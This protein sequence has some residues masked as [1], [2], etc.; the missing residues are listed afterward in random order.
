MAMVNT[1][2]YSGVVLGIGLGAELGDFIDLDARHHLV[3]NH[4]AF[5]DTLGQRLGHGRHRHAD[6]RGA[7]GGQ[8]LVGQAGRGA[9][10]HALEVFHRLHLLLGGEQVAGAMDVDGED[11][12]VLELVLGIGLGEFPGGAAGGL[13]I[14]HGEGQFEDFR[15]REAVGRVAEHGP[16]HVGDA[17]LGLVEELGRR[18]AELHGRIDLA[19]DAV[20]GFLAELGAPGL[21]YADLDEGRR[22]KKVVHLQCHFLRLGRERGSPAIDAAI[23]VFATAFSSTSPL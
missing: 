10:F 6:R 15:H 7:H 12:D 19:L 20:V 16:H 22:R 14:G 9:E 23:R 2:V 3:G 13:G 21:E 1:V 4:G 18:A 8:H 11:L 5:D 17:I